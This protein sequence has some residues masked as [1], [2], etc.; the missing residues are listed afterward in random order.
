[1]S[2]V[3]ALSGCGPRLEVG[4]TA[5]G[6]GAA[7]FVALAGARPRNE[8]IVAAVDLLLRGAG[9][10][11]DQ[12]VGI[13]ATRGPGSFTGLR[14]TLATAQA[15][16]LA[17]GLAGHAFS[18]LLVQAERTRDTEVVAVQPARRGVV[19]AERYSRTADALSPQ[20]EPELIAIEALAEGGLPVVAPD[21]LFLPDGIRRARTHAT[22]PEAL[23]NLYER[24]DDAD[25][26]TLVPL[27]LEPPAAKPPRRVSQPWQPYLKES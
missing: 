25:P 20:G 19:Y 6:G 5:S 1:M 14:V 10:R 13:A 23:L 3:L 7:S 9:I 27:Y 21:G 15:L 4:L 11:P 16:A 17:H 24:L 18:S 12:L 2:A 8:L 22:T 26:A